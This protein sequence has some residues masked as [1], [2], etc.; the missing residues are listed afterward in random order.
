MAQ[1]KGHPEGEQLNITPTT[2]FSEC[3]DMGGVSWQPARDDD[4]KPVINDK[5]QSLGNCI[6]KNS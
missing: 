5:G 2:T 4:G 3:K 1:K 6:H